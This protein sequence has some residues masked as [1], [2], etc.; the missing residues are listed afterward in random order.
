MAPSGVLVLLVLASGAPD[1][2]LAPDLV[3]V[4]VLVM[5][6]GAAL[7]VRESEGVRE[8]EAVL[9]DRESVA[10]SPA[11]KLRL[12]AAAILEPDRPRLVRWEI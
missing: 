11:Q 12:A 8:S 7:A 2:V 9:R 1:S 6:D 4:L 10:V 5:V 3:P